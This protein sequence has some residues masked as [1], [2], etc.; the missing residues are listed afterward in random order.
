MFLLIFVNRSKLIPDFALTLHFLHLIVVSFYTRE[1]PSNKLWWG[2]MTVS[3]AMM[4]FLGIWACQWRELQPL[5]FG[6]RAAA[7]PE[8]ANGHLESGGVGG[9]TKVESAIGRILGHGRRAE[10]GSYEMVRMR[11]EGPP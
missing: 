11:E 1:F 3:A 4:T 10:G 6:G 8:A 9:S 5:A 7:Q 2:L